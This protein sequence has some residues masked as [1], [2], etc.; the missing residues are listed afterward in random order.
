MSRLWH[1]AGDYTMLAAI[2]FT[3]WAGSWRWNELQR[4]QLD[5][6]ERLTRWTKAQ[7]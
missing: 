2:R 6:A 5:E 4:R 1:L 7:R 3:R